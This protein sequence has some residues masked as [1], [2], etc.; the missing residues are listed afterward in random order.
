LITPRLLTVARRL[1]VKAEII[2]GELLRDGVRLVPGGHYWTL[3]G[4]AIVDSPEPGVF[5]V[6]TAAQRPGMTYQPITRRPA[7]GASVKGAR[8]L[9][10]QADAL[11]NPP[12]RPIRRL[13]G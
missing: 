10:R 9:M 3:V 2:G 13:S 12:S 11:A 7:G 6:A 8:A 5:N 1:G 4:E